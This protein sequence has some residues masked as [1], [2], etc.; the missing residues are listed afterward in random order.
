MQYY[1][2]RMDT[3]DLEYVYREMR[4]QVKRLERRIRDKDQGVESDDDEG[5]EGVELIR[6]SGMI[7][8]HNHN[9]P[10]SKNDDKPGE[11]EDELGSTEPEAFKLDPSDFANGLDYVKSFV[12]E[13]RKKHISDQ[14][15]EVR[16]RE[17][18]GYSF[19][20][21]NL[22]PRSFRKAL[23]DKR[24]KPLKGDAYYLTAIVPILKETYRAFFNGTKKPSYSCVGKELV[25]DPYVIGILTTSPIGEIPPVTLCE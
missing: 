21:E 9:M 16:R 18:L 25:R 7:H 3:I 4:K 23:V 1:E 12:K 24:N 2:K 10:V 11:D 17:S 15:N 5:C 20:T 14:R 22:Q 6:D 13:T 19:K 8:N